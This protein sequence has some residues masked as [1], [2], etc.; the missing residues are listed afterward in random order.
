MMT[1]SSHEPF[2]VP[3][4]TVIEGDDDESKFL[5]SAYYTDK[6]LGEFI[7]KAKQTSWWNNTLVVITADHGHPMPGNGNFSSAN[8]YKIPMLWLGGALNTKDTVI[9]TLAGQTDI[10]NTI[11]GQVAKQNDHFNFS[12]DILNPAYSPFAIFIFNNGFGFIQPGK[13]LVYDN[14]GKSLIVD[15]KN[16]PEDLEYGKSFMQK[17]YWDFNSR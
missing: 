7:V 13:L 10:A 4:K 5:N 12:H 6:E 3:M 2:Q 14:N 8:R 11:L 1:Q 9:H 15:E 17:L 16:S